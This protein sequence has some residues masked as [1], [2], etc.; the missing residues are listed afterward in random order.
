MHEFKNAIC[1]GDVGPNIA[2]E[3]GFL[4]CKNSPPARMQECKMPR[5]LLGESCGGGEQSPPQECKNAKCPGDSWANLAGGFLPCKNSPPRRNAI[6]PRDPWANL[7]G[8]F[9]PCKSSP[10]LARLQECKMPKGLLGKSCGVMN[11]PPAIMQECKMPNRLLGQ[12]CR[13]G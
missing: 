9:H 12:S 8:G 4:P 7:A 10:P 11:S 13:G 3:G 5:G 1:P 6:C 2:G